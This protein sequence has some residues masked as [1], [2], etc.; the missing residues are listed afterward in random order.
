[1]PYT[2]PPLPYARNA[3]EPYMSEETLNYHYGKHHQAY[4]DKLNAA[5]ADTSEPHTPL[6]TLIQTTTGG[7]FNNAAQVWN[8]TFFWHCLSAEHNQSIPDTVSEA[9]N[10]AFNSVAEFK[11]QFSEQALSLFGSG[12]MWL[13]RDKS[14]SLALK[15]TSNAQ[16][17]LQEGETPLLT[18]DVWEHAYYIDTRNNRAQYIEN[19]WHLVNWRTVAQRLSQ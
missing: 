7:V 19:F 13:I 8:H 14:G 5:M 4:V 12:W 1:M 18:C 10:E 2:L 15:Q 17:P 3:L 6:E 9:L 16:C 11:Q